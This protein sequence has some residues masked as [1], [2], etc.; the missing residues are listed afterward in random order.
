MYL[1]AFFLVINTM[2]RNKVGFTNLFKT[3]NVGRVRLNCP[4]AFT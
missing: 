1:Y 3:V 4:L 2:I